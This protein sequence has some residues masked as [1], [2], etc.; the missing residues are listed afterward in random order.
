MNEA[1]S[2]GFDPQLW[3]QFMSGQAPMMQGLMGNYL[4]QSQKLFLQM[5]E[6]FQNAGS[7]FPGMPGFTPPKK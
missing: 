6:Q 3:S 4:E 5:Q 1:H 2:K 7:M